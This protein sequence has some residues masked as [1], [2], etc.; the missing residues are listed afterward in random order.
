MKKVWNIL[1]DIA[2]VIL[3][4][5]LVVVILQKFTNN[6][7]TVGGLHI[8]SIVSESMVPE[9]NIGDILVSKTTPPS[10]L[11]I[12]DDITYLG[13]KGELK[14]L[15]ITHRIIQIKESN[16]KYSFITKG[17]ANEVEDPEIEQGQVIG[18]VVYKTVIFSF[19]GRL[20]RNVII[21]YILFVGVGVSVSYSFITNFI[22]KGGKDEKDD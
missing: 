7:M 14:G 16:G 15:F 10:E 20:M 13:E 19:L 2:T 17:I 21:Y 1:K 3:L 9:Y 8:F 11:K 6:R 22:M 12:G 4:M 18:K 5:I